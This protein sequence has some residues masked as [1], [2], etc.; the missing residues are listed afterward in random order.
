MDSS[1]EISRQLGRAALK[2]CPEYRAASLPKCGSSKV[3]SV[4]VMAVGISIVLFE[5]AEKDWCLSCVC[6]VQC[7]QFL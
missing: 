5:N 2:L 6:A 4:C 3:L 7:F 1:N